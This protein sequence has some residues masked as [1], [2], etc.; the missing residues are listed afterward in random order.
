M[1]G[2]LVFV[3]QCSIYEVCRRTMCCFFCVNWK[4]NGCVGWELK[5]GWRRDGTSQGAMF[6]RGWGSC[7]NH[8]LCESLG[9][10]CMPSGLTPGL[11]ANMYICLRRLDLFPSRMTDSERWGWE[12]HGGGCRSLME[13]PTSESLAGDK[14]LSTM[15]AHCGDPYA[16]NHC[17]ARDVGPRCSF[18]AATVNFWTR[19]ATIMEEN[20][21]DCELSRQPLVQSLSANTRTPTLLTSLPQPPK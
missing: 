6:R 1:G 19:R 8:K 18:N 5:C 9:I 10:S 13:G 15:L 20:I 3:Y 17:A 14:D 4:R 21:I 2:S 7:L 11:A 12:P 16:L